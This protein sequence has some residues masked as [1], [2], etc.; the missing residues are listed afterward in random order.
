MDLDQILPV[1]VGSAVLAFLY[2]R[3]IGKTASV[4]A[5]KLVAEGALLLDVRS[6]GEF[7]GA[8]LPG[9]VNIPVGEVG[10]R[11]AEL[12]PRERP[13][14]VYCASGMRSASAA[15]QLRALGFQHVHDLGGMGRW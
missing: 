1:L 9:A 8:H 2:I 5:R 10:G 11:A 12:G 14:V 7:A 3:F 13:I 15:S 4:D 6:P